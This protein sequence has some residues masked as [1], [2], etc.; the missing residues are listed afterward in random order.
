MTS[1][2]GD[3]ENLLRRLAGRRALAQ[4]TILFERLWPALWPPLGVAGVFMCIALLDL[5]RM[6]PAW[7]HIGLL[8]IAFLLVAGLLI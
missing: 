1:S 3:L 8:L 2:G 4:I 6:L 5:P 7:A